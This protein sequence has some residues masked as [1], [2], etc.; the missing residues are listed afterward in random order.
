MRKIISILIMT[1]FLA[2]CHPYR[3]TVEQGNL[4]D[5]KM[6]NKIQL[7]MD[8]QQVNAILGAPVLEDLFNNNERL[9]VY[10]KQVNGGKIT[11]NK[12]ILVFQNNKLVQIK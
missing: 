8:K 12:L 2:G 6:I 7:G 10:T 5:S 9:Y 4:I 1:W 11:K 3:V